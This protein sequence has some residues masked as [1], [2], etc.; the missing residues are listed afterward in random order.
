[1]ASFIL[2]MLA[3]LHTLV[4][5]QSC[6]VGLVA[7]LSVLLF[8]RSKSVK[9]PVPGPFT[10]PIF[11]SIFVL[12][13][14]LSPYRRHQIRC[15][16]AIKYG[17]IYRFQIGKLKAIFLNDVGLLKEAFITK[18]EIISD[19]GGANRDDDIAVMFGAGKGI[20][21]S[22]YD[23][24]FKERKTLALHSM[25]DFGFGGKSLEETS[26]EETV[27]LN[28]RFKMVA[29]TATPTD[30]HQTLIHLAVSNVICSV[31]FGRRFDYD[32]EKFNTAVNGIRFLFS[33]RTGLI[34]R[35]PLVA[36]LPAVQKRLAEEEQQARNV[37]SFIEEQIQL[38]KEEFDPNCPKD[39]IDLCL[40][41]EHLDRESAQ[42]S[43]IGPDNIKK[44]IIDMFFAGT[45]TTAS[46]LSWFMLYMIRF[47]EIQRECQKEIDEVLE[48]QGDLSNLNTTK[49]FPYTTATL[50]ETQRISSI[51]PTSLPHIVRENTT[52]GGFDVEKGSM[53]FA[54]IRFLHLDERY[55]KNPETFDPER[56]LDPS[57][58]AKVI[59]HTNFVPFSIGKRRCLGMNL[60]KAEYS[61]FAISL[62]RNLSLKMVDP[63]QPPT[64]EGSGIIYSPTPFKMLMEWRQEVE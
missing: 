58:P 22:N 64:L 59:E 18:G 13:A 54:N 62:L 55:W 35:I 24:D 16:L 37:L 11:G 7:T 45:D 29:D 27:F 40:Q 15:D 19:R 49:C 44:I 8:R 38:H 32:D 3:K 56:W 30:L 5:L 53:V 14:L 10:I 26:M 60:A 61:V 43:R 51:A 2:L 23:K 46:S 36:R 48:T 47:P 12:P 42:K 6:L 1:M 50:L 63:L 31:V 41:K 21:A 33:Q 39:F 25:K 4:S 34:S 9:N 28:N 57:D 17:K 20:G 52:L